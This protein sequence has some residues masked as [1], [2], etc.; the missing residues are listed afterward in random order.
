MKRTLVLGTLTVTAALIG[1]SAALAQEYKTRDQVK[2]EL[3]EANRA[4]TILSGDGTLWRDLGVPH[5]ADDSDRTGNTQERVRAALAEAGRAGSIL[6]GDGT[7]WRD[8]G[9]PVYLAGAAPSDGKTRERV[10]AELAEADRNGS[11]LSGDGT[12]WQDLGTL[13]GFTTTSFVA[14]TKPS[15]GASVMA[16]TDR[17]LDAGSGEN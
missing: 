1:S 8:L 12:L 5:G 7:L 2:A 11:I 10:R 15:A 3:A 17:S 4:G 6:S 13:H 14:Q 16:G 9:S